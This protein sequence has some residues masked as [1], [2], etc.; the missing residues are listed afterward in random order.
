M[1]KTGK[2]VVKGLHGDLRPFILYVYSLHGLK[3]VYDKLKIPCK[4]SGRVGLLSLVISGIE[5]LAISCSE[6]RDIKLL[7]LDSQDVNNAYSGGEWVIRMCEGEGN[8]LYVEIFHGQILELDCTHTVF[9]K[10]KIINTQIEGH[11]KGICYAPSPHKLLVASTGKKVVAI[12]CD[13]GKMVWKR[14]CRSLYHAHYDPH[15]PHGLAYSKIHNAILLVDGFTSRILVL[16][17]PT[18]YTKQIIDLP[19]MGHFRNLY[20]NGNQLVLR[21][22]NFRKKYISFFSVY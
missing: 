20:L 18:G 11:L 19:G 2:V 21:H 13:S 8:T 14:K 7:N 1:K 3:L 12:A 15:D 6:C 5:L 16:E 10:R 4:H 17:P 9:S 22:N